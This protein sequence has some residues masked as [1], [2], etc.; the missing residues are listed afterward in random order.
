MSLTVLDWIVRGVLDRGWVTGTRDG[1]VWRLR[2]RRV[3]GSG[4]TVEPLAP[5]RSPLGR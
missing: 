5:Y 2:A 4:A 3:A 1:V